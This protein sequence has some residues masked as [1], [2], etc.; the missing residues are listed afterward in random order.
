MPLNIKES[1]NNLLTNITQEQVDTW[2]ENQEEEK[3]SVEEFKK[4]FSEY[5]NK[6]LISLI[7]AIS[8]SKNIS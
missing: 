5:S 2:C 6:G 8:M 3:I 7:T 1:I 4:R